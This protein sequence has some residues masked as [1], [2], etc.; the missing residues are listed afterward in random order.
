[1]EHLQGP[2]GIELGNCGIRVAI[3]VGIGEISIGPRYYR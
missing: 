3:A 1:M 2:S